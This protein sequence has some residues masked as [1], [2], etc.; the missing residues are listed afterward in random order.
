MEIVLGNA[1][2]LGQETR[3]EHRALESDMKIFTFYT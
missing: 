1:G 3:D 2:S